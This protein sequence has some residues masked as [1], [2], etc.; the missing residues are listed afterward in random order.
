MV[1]NWFQLLA[2]DLKVLRLTALVFSVDL[3]RIITRSSTVTH[4]YHMQVLEC[5][6]LSAIK[7]VRTSELLRVTV[8]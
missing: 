1:M 4:G 6:L 8:A 7:Q 2:M 5:L 3:Q